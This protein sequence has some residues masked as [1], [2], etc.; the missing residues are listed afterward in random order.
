MSFVSNARGDLLGLL[1]HLG[2]TPTQSA[3]KPVAFTTSD[4][5]LDSADN[6]VCNAFRSDP[7]TTNPA[8]V[9]LRTAAG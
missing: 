1:R 8:S 5:R 4:Q 9:R 6:K 3:R 7:T 2:P